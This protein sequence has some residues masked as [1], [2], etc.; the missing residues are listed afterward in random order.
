[1]VTEERLA[2]EIDPRGLAQAEEEVQEQ[3]HVRGGVGH[4]LGPSAV[5]R[6]PP[7]I[8]RGGRGQHEVEPVLDLRTLVCEDNAQFAEKAE[9]TSGMAAG[10]QHAVLLSHQQ[11]VGADRPRAQCPSDRLPLRVRH[12]AVR[13]VVRPG[14]EV[15]HGHMRLVVVWDGGG[16]VRIPPRE[17]HQSLDRGPTE[18]LL[19]ADEVHEREELSV[20]SELPGVH[21]RVPPDPAP[22]VVIHGPVG[23]E[24]RLGHREVLREPVLRLFL[25]PLPFLGQLAFAPPTER[26]DPARGQQVSGM[27][28]RDP[29]DPLTGRRDHEF[30]RVLRDPEGKRLTPSVVLPAAQGSPGPMPRARWQRLQHDPEGPASYR[31]CPGLRGVERLVRTDAEFIGRGPVYRMPHEPRRIEVRLAPIKGATAVYQGIRRAEFAHGIVLSELSRCG[32]AFRDRRQPISLDFRMRVLRPVPKTPCFYPR[33]GVYFQR[34]KEA[35]TMIKTKLP[36]LLAERRMKQYELAQKAG[37]SKNTV[38]SICNDNWKGISREVMDTLC[39][40]LDIQVG[41]LFEYVPTLEFLHVEEIGPDDPDY[42]LAVEREK[43]E[44]VPLAACSELFEHLDRI[45][46]KA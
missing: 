17:L 46:G 5:S 6:A 14:A 4:A 8:H 30:R 37:I 44:S 40:T 20:L 36:V 21:H 23:E 45:R 27:F 7:G 41:D 26:V 31:I 15:D 29:G 10:A 19:A 18:A 32:K 35:M 28:G 16:A 34:R 3:V 25:E 12:Q 22:S 42:L 9:H 33:D 24:R 11:R 39:E 38:S 1:M 2:V 13:P 43:E